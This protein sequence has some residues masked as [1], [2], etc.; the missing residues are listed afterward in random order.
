M[1]KISFL[2]IMPDFDTGK[3]RVKLYSD[4]RINRVDYSLQNSEFVAAE[5][6]ESCNEFVFTVCD[7][8]PWTIEDP[9]LY[10]LNVNIEYSDGSTE[11]ISDT[12]GM[13]KLSVCND[14]ILL[15]N[16][17]FYMRAYIRGTA[18]H[19]HENLCNLSETEFYEKN[20]LSA[21]SFGFNTIRFHSKIPPKECFEAADRFGM[22]IHIEMR[23]ISEK[24]DNLKEMIRGNDIFASDD[25]I[26]NIV[27]SLMNHPSF[28]VYCIGNEIKHPGVNPKVMHIANLIKKLDPSRLFIDTCAHGEFDRDYVEFD[29]QHM[30]YYYPFGKHYDMFE[31]TD[32]L[33]VYGSCKGAEMTARGGC[34]DA[35]F[36]ITRGIETTRPI[37][38]HEVCHYTALRDIFSL[39]KKFEKYGREKPWWIDEQKKM[40][41]AKGLT[42][43]FPKM[44]YA[45]KEFQLMSWK[46]GIEAIRRSPI[47]RGF[48][49]L[50]F[51]DT[52]I[53]ENS[54][55]LVDCFDDLSY[56]KPEQFLKFNGDTVLLADLPKRS[57]FESEEVEIPV[58][59]SNYSQKNY[60]ECR[61]EFELVDSRNGEIALRGSFH[62]IDLTKRGLSK[63]LKLKLVF[64]TLDSS[65]PY[66]LVT[67]LFSENCEDIIEND[68]RIWC[69]VNKPEKLNTT[70]CSFKLNRINAAL[71]YKH[72]DTC[73]GEKLL[74][75]DTLDDNVLNALEQGENVFLLYYSDATRHVRDGKNNSKYSFRTTWERFKAVIWDR[76]TNYGGI[77]NKPEALAG[78]PHNQISDLVF[79]NLI[80]DSDKIILDD[81][82]VPITPIFECTDKSVRDRFDVRGAGFEYP[83]FQYDRTLRKFSYISELKVG[84]GKLLISGMNFSGLETGTPET[85]GMFEALLNYANSGD[86]SPTAAISLDALKK[87]LSENSSKGVVRER[88]MTQFWQLDNTP[89]ES[90]EYWHNSKAYILEGEKEQNK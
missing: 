47:L 20:I 54:N 22:F 6:D 90:A 32:N 49:M 5:L 73:K 74:V 13:R 8:H 51:A 50:Q 4:D 53:Y 39:E 37:I 34:G 70:G 88:M 28:M 80:E 9:Y 66:R 62:N 12:F 41:E 21:K 14:N 58:Y 40:L 16:I 57:F 79:Y 43:K 81:F 52:E 15:N 60:G 61:F 82:P 56:I 24:Y 17:P 27:K 1:N 89:V 64:P 77:I 45:S 7:I 11:N 75:T 23:N 87:Y 26:K 55:G 83:D 86:F 19:D 30:S 38:A 31:N 71:R 59:V 42:N 29:V 85:C 18:C 84:K 36:K 2:N 68:W 65:T 33:I 44:F 3:T 63:I 67:R 72:I 48:H 69:F 76:G 35:A 10:H 78:F 25:T 46:L